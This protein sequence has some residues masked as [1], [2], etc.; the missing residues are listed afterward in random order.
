MAESIRSFLGFPR[1]SGAEADTAFLALFDS[2]PQGAALLDS[3]D[4]VL[5]ANT[6]LRD[7]IGP[8]LPLR[9]GT[10]AILL[11]DP[12][13]RDAVRTW[14][15]EGGAEPLEAALGAPEGQTPTLTLLRL[16]PLP[17]GRRILLAE[18][19]SE[20]SRRRE[21]AEAGERL[22]AI[23][24][25][26]GGI[27]HD[28]NNLLAIILGAMDG[29]VLAVP[30]IRDELRPAQDAAARGA[31]LVRRLLAFARRQQLEPRILDLDEAVQAATPMLR[32]LLGPRITLEIHPGALG[33]RIRVDPVQLDQV[34]L[35]L[36][37]NARDAMGG[38]GT[39]TIAT[40]TAI[41]LQEEPGFPDPLP[42]GRWAVLDITDTGPGIPPDIL[43]HIIE[44]FFTT[45]ATQG[46][47]G[48]GLATI[49]GIVRQS[50]GAMRIE[51][52]PGLTR[53][54]IH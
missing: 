30:R 33:R 6:P 37:T 4:S 3:A 11:F 8:A 34:L 16:A 42:P 25:L 39:L 22:R 26:A 20:R 2:L 17:E 36:A 45:R 47:T 15:H 38:E 43:P 5:R 13:A 52:R 12:P 51:S 46:G 29:A 49:H 21:E 48:L 31:A 9:P 41:S 18:D 7:M 32:S 10:P 24:Q 50:G 44:P 1:N 19:L 14:L 23:G 28:V 40:D 35:N 53:F 54:R 27:A